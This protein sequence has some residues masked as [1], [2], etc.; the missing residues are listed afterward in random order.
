M[1]MS[2]LFHFIENLTKKTKI[3]AKKKMQKRSN[4]EERD[5]ESKEG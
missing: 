4:E 3:I 1:L 2:F 5:K